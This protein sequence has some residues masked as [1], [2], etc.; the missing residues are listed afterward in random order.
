MDKP[1]AADHPLHP[2]I[3]NR[4]SPRAFDTVRPVERE[5][6]LAILE[7]ARWAPSSSNEQPWTFIVAT[8]DQPE[9]FERLL[10]CLVEAN[11][12]WAKNAA[13]LVIAVAKRHFE[14][15]GTPNR[16][17]SHDVGLALGNL[18]IQATA[19]GLAVHYMAGFEPSKARQVCT[20]PETHEPFTMAAL[21]YA[22]EPSTLPEEYRQREVAPRV[23]KP[24]NQI[25]HSG[26]FGQTA[27]WVQ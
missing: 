23:R 10:S 18:A 13:V 22:A 2:L 25:V 16:H 24:L 4:W 19:L 21:G 3:A 9:D 11:Q 15:N 26:K 17:A 6:L 12:K 8:R 14:R 27:S 7:A 1:A 5:K 20:I